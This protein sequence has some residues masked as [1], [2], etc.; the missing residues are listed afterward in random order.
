MRDGK[1]IIFTQHALI[2]AKEKLHI[3]D[4]KKMIQ[5]FQGALRYDDN[6]RYAYYYDK[7]LTKYVVEENKDNFIIITLYP[8]TK[9]S[10]AE[11]N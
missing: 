9:E 6:S 7:S 8:T 3:S 11:N 4:E 2:R 1:K 10:I 5:K